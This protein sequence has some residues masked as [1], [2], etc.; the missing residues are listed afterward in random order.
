M[1]KTTEIIVPAKFI[2]LTAQILA[3]IIVMVTREDNIF[4]TLPPDTNIDDTDYE[5]AEI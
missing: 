3:V 1:Y 2:T 5:S 4:A